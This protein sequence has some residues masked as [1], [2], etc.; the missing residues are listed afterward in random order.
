VFGFAGVRPQGDVLAVD[1]RLPPDWAALELCLRFRGSQLRLR[2]DRRGVELDA[3]PD[4][5]LRRRNR[6][7]EV[8]LR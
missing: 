1:P 2:I 8:T 3:A 6:I 5:R 7:W 4:L